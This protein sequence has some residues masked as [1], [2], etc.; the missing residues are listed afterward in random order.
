VNRID[1]LT[2]EHVVAKHCLAMLSDGVRT[3]TMPFLLS[4][5]T[6]PQDAG[7]ALDADRD[8]VLRDW[9]ITASRGPETLD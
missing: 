6:P 9:G 4:D 8:A 5:Y 2:D 3:V 1:V 7:P